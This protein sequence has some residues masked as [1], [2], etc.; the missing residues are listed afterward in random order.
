MNRKGKTASPTTNEWA[1]AEAA[2]YGIQRDDQA[3]PAFFRAGT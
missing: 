2:G 1:F 3:M